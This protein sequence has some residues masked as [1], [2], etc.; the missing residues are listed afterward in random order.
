MTKKDYVL[1][2][3]AVSDMFLGHKDWV[4]NLEQV[5]NKLADALQAQNPLFNR[6][7]FLTACGVIL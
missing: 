3:K 1:I 2:A 7:K 5:S 4:R 6:E